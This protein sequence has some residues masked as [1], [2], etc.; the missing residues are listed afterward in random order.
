[1]ALINPNKPRTVT[2][3]E[4]EIELEPETRNNG[5][6]KR[7]T[8]YIRDDILARFGKGTPYFRQLSEITENLLV[9]FLELENLDQVHKQIQEEELKLKALKETKKRLEI[10]H[11]IKIKSELQDQEKIKKF[12]DEL[13]SF[14]SELNNQYYVLPGL[15]VNEKT[16]IKQGLIDI[17]IDKRLKEANELGIELTKEKFKEFFDM[18]VKNEITKYEDYLVMKD[19]K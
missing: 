12:Y 5:T 2:E 17:L 19:M 4:I 16:N 11:D 14:V 9:Q 18:Y 7:T 10:E 6:K 3:P 13:A 15:K 8:L 1:M